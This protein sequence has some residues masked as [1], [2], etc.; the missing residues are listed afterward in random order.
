[1]V[2]NEVA[3]EEINQTTWSH[4]NIILYTQS[5]KLLYRSDGT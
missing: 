5:G 2:N 4:S 3:L 1:M